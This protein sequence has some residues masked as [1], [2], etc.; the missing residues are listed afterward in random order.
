T[1]AENGVYIFNGAASALTRAA[2]MA[3][4]AVLATGTAVSTEGGT[5]QANQIWH[6]TTPADGTWT[7]AT[8]ATTWSQL[9]GGAGVTSFQ[10]R[11][12]A[13][14]LTKADVTGTGLA[15]S[16]VRSEE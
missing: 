7:V 13:V 15:A 2:D 5:T 14:T 8:T 1:A 10:T 9:G 12:G 4:A 11:T 3:A 16:D 6:V